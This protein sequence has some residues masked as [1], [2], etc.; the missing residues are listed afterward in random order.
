MILS[1]FKKTS[2][3][4]EF[5]I[6]ILPISLL[7]SSLISEIFI[8]TLVFVFFWKVQKIE[9]V[10]ILKNKII[11]SIFILYIF[12]I[13]NY[14]FNISRN[15]DFARSFFFIRLINKLIY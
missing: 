12:L 14:F 10:S 6:I 13:I 4:I 11:I 15:P 7:F 2:F 9:L 8:L 3:Y 1:D 5:I